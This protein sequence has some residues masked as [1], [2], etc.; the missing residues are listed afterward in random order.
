M[1]RLIDRLLV[2]LALGLLAIL[3]AGIAIDLIAKLLIHLFAQVNSSIL[4]ALLF[5]VA[6]AVFTTGL[7]VRGVRALASP[8]S[9]RRR[10]EGGQARQARQAVRR[11]AP[12]VPAAGARVVPEDRDPAFGGEEE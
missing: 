2:Y 10:E 1:R 8:G 5:L 4:G 12:D 7:L 6:A 9:T 3:A 11:P